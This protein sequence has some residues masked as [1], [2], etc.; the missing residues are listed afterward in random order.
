MATLSATI[1]EIM[2]AIIDA[3]L[4]ECP[5]CFYHEISNLRL[6]LIS[7]LCHWQHSHNKN[8]LFML[9]TYT[10]ASKPV[11]ALALCSFNYL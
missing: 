5:E 4:L 9:Y 11:S 8:L 2:H 6:H 1:L 7:L 3:S 10:L